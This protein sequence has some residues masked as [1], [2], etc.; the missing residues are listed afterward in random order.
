[1]SM[2]VLQA[3]ILAIIQGI[4]EFLPISSSGHLVLA[5]KVMGLATPPVAF[6]ILLHVATLGAI[7]WFLGRKLKQSLRMWKLVIVGSIP[8]GVVGLLVQPY[9]EDIFN[10]LAIVGVGLVV[11]GIVLLATKFKDK[12]QQ[13]SY[14]TAVLIGMAQAV[15]ILPG[16]SRSGSTIAT[17][18]WLGV[19]SQEALRFSLLL[20][21][22]AILGA[23]MLE[24]DKLLNNGTSLEINLIGFGVALVVGLAAL[25]LQNLLD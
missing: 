23:Q 16:V 5:Q 24:I 19:G 10:S 9:L 21:V 12:H 14:K 20:A 2:N 4:A 18:L 11:T 15:A 22:P 7:F 1:M 3:V 8:A 6:D 17:A 25:K 13:L